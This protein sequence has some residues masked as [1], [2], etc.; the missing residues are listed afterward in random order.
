MRKIVNLCYKI[1]KFQIRNDGLVGFNP[2]KE[3]QAIKLI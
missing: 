2:S 1:Y 3:I